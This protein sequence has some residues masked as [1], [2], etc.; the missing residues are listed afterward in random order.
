MTATS[1]AVPSWAVASALIVVEEHSTDVAT[2][3]AD[4]QP[5]AAAVVECRVRI[6]LEHCQEMQIWFLCDCLP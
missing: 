4:E 2:A 6:A 1:V 5:V 3:F